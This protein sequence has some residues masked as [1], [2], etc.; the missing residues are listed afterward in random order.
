MRWKRARNLLALWLVAC[1][2]PAGFAA[3]PR[4]N[5]P[6][7]TWSAVR[8]QLDREAKSFRSLS[9]AMDRT[10]VTVVVNDR[11]TEHGDISVRGDKMLLQFKAPD[12][13]TILRT[14]DNLYIYNPGLKRVEEYNLG[15]NRALVEQFLQLGFGSRGSELEKDYDIKLLPEQRMDDQMVVVLDLT[16]KSHQ[17]RR[18]ISRI[19]IWMSEATWL[20]VQQEFY[21]AGSGDYSIVRYSNVVRNPEIPDSRFRPSWPKGTQK[22]KMQT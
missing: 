12:Q 6:S 16:P 2:A 21:E 3:S 13:R 19:Q 14:G 10:K 8:E 4:Q 15:K 17:V 22:V 7:W 5:R 9:A 11:S 18:E 1:L 20:P